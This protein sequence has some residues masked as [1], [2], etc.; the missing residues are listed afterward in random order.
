MPFPQAEFEIAS[1]IS[2]DRA[3]AVRALDNV[4]L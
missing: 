3:N 1:P 4:N 2:V